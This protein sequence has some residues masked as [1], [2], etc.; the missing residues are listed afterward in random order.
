MPNKQKFGQRGEWYV[1]IQFLLFIL[2]FL[3]PLALPE[4]VQ[5]PPPLD[6]LGIG[7]GVILLGAGGLIAMFGVLSLGR[8]LTAVPYP[9]DEAKLVEDGAYRYVRHPIYGGII[10]GSFGWGLLTNSI[11]ALVLSVVL[12]LFFDIKSRREEQW[13][14]EKYTNYSDYQRRV[15]KL[16]PLIY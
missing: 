12:F 9:K 16:I 11:L 10:I 8:N 7:M 4:I 13:L 6:L 1:A 2:I 3:E 14:A 5:W 15:R